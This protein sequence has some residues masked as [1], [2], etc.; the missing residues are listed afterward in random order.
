MQVNPVSQ[1]IYSK[2]NFQRKEKAQS[3]HTSPMRSAAKAIVV[4]PFLTPFLMTGCD[5]DR[6]FKFE[7]EY[8]H[9]YKDTT[10]TDSSH[11][12]A[13]ARTFIIPVSGLDI[14]G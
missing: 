7:N 13:E 2:V 11:K 8:D 1:N 9:C 3:E 10:A 4:I 14:E 12:H 5:K 6:E